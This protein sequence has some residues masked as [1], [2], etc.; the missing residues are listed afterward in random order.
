[1]D[2]G[3]SNRPAAHQPFPTISSPTTPLFHNQITTDTSFK[4]KTNNENTFLLTSHLHQP[5]CAFPTRIRQLRHPPTKQ[6]TTIKP[7]PRR[8][9]H[10]LVGWCSWSS[11]QSNTLKVPGSSPGPIKIS[12]HVAQLPRSSTFCVYHPLR[13]SLICADTCHGLHND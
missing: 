10:P 4:C 12:E 1:M 8:Y 7:D 6:S 5:T 13:Q 3:F 11:H 9:K 2:L